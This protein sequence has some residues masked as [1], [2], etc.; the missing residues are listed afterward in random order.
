MRNSTCKL[1]QPTEASVCKRDSSDAT[2]MN[3]LDTPVGHLCKLAA[4]QER[5]L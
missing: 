3:D 2:T 1:E 4:A 5:K